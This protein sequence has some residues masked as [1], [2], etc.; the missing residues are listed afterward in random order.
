[1][2]ISDTN[3]YPLLY[4]SWAEGKRRAR[5]NTLTGGGRR[6]SLRER[7]AAAL[8]G[9]PPQFGS[10]LLPLP[11]SPWWGNGKQCDKVVVVVAG[12]YNLHD[13]DIFCKDRSPLSA[14]S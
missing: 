9:W 8:P 7:G 4:E 6:L 5:C 3:K 10:P 1:M 12:V 2:L 13:H 14:D 11:S